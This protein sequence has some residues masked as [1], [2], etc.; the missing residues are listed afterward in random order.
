VA[1]EAAASRSDERVVPL[2]DRYL[3]RFPGGRYAAS[4]SRART[5]FGDVAK[6][7]GALTWT[8]PCGDAR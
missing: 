1:I 4:A 6:A 3:A 5:R 7:R 2:A 8:I